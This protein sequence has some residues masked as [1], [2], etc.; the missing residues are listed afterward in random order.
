V[1]IL[2]VITVVKDD[3]TGLLRTLDSLTTQ[4]NLAP[5]SIDWELVIVD[6]SSPPAEITLDLGLN[7][8]Y[9]WQEPAGIYSAMNYG[10]SQAHGTYLL[11]LN[12]GDTLA[13]SDSLAKLI[14]LLT[15]SSPEWAF[16]PVLFSSEFGRALVEPDWVYEREVRRLFA[17]GLFP[18]HQGT[19]IKRDLVNSL[20]GFDS[21]YQI[22]SDY[23]LMLRA[24]SVA[25]PL[26]ID[27]PIANFQQG[28]ASTQ[29]W[30]TAAKEFHQAR[31]EVFKPRGWA[32]FQEWSDTAVGY[33]KTG[34]GHAVAGVRRG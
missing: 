6:G 33:L 18:A 31:V 12:A 27:F 10:V 19:L 11:F 21:R 32:Q 24:S 34:L 26:R 8:R 22:A 17:R 1:P 2:S 30:R 29:H 23:H 15:H 9:F 14:S 7:S 4:E 16:G 25:K 13:T 20:N 5:H 3:A 28:G